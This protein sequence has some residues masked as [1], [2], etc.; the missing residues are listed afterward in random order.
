MKYVD[1]KKFTDEN[2]AQPIYLFE[3]EEGYFREKGEE[4]LKARFLQEASLDYASFDGSDLKGEKMKALADAAYCFP[5]ISQK[6]FVRVTEFYPTE[7]EFDAYLKPLFDD[8]PASG[9]LLIINTGKGK[10]GTAA[11]AKKSNVT[12]VDC[13]RS[14]EETIKRWISITCKRAGIYADGITCGKL[15]A[16][17]VNDMSRI[18]KETEKLIA[19]CAAQGEAKLT[20]EIVD[21]LV[22]PDSDYK[23]YELANAL[24]RKNY[25]EY[26]KIVKDL[27]TRGFNEAALLSA[28][29][30]YFKGLYETSLCK[31]SDKEVAATLGIKEYAAKKNREQAAKFSKEGLL[32]TYQAVYEAVSGIKGGM[33][34][35]SGAFKTATMRLFFGETQKNR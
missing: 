28:L 5:F 16:Y 30:S 17:C 24:A 8:P 27:S 26:M 23:I 29:V 7:K 33:L 34:T 15:A 6:R 32:S 9:L 4:L 2:G 19:Y 3:G 1:F 31:G 13:A 10:A 22:Y 11:L 14:D 12:Y 18:A 35:P 20:D 25:S 21:G